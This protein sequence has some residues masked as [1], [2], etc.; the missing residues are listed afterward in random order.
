MQSMTDCWSVNGEGMLNRG[1]SEGISRTGGTP[2]GGSRMLPWVALLLAALA[3]LGVAL[4]H[5]QVNPARELASVR[6]SA[7]QGDHGSQLLLGLMFHEGRDGLA[8]D[9]VSASRWLEASAGG[10]NPYAAD[11]LGTWY[12]EGVGVPVEPQTAVQWWR[13][14]AQRGLPAGERD[15]GK[16]YLKGIGVS[17]DY[18]QARLWLDRA[19]ARNDAG[20]R[21]LLQ[22]MYR[23]GLAVDADLA[24]GQGWWA[25]L[26]AL[27]SGGARTASGSRGEVLQVLAR[28]GQGLMSR[29][30]AGDPSAQYQ[31]A[32]RYRTGVWVAQDPQHAL[33]W[34]EQAAGNGNHLAMTT[35]ARIYADGLMGLS[36]DPK[37]AQYW[38]H[39][40]SVRG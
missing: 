28:E 37:R 16:A 13:M 40:A 35:L 17:R 25:K 31:L 7:E 34:F 36:P 14:A 26:S 29:A 3:L 19:A 6:H 18:E 2:P 8:R 21:A 39:R 22:D 11:T 20:A 27:L 32:W 10:G 1:R 15:L 23:R 9:D 5:T 4:A 30:E 38:R 12:A 24:K 33:H